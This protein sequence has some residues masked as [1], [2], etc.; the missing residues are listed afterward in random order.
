VEDRLLD[1]IAL[2]VRHRSM[3][4]SFSWHV[5]PLWHRTVRLMT[6]KIPCS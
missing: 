2:E 1:L 6:R 5:K 4:V 3:H